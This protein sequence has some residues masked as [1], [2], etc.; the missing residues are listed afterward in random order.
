MQTAVF[1]DR[2]HMR[3]TSALRSSK[4]GKSSGA[5]ENACRVEEGHMCQESGTLVEGA[6]KYCTFAVATCTSMSTKA[7]VLVHLRQPSRTRPI[8]V[9]TCGSFNGLLVLQQA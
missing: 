9:G 6:N 2:V 1:I 5:L 8:H 7:F 4:T 3:F